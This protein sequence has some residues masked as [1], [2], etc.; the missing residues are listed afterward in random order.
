MNI[1]E[2]IAIYTSDETYENICNDSFPI[3]V[4]LICDRNTK[5]V[6]LLNGMSAELGMNE[7]ASEDWYVVR[8]Q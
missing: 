5:R 7:L 6:Y 8:N 2:A 4:K 3:P 1:S